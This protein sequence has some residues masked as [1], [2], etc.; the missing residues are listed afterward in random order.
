MS[1]RQYMDKREVSGV[2]RSPFWHLLLVTRLLSSCVVVMSAPEEDEEVAQ[3]AEEEEDMDQ[4]QEEAEQEEPEEEQDED[5][6]SGI[7][8]AA[9]KSSGRKGPG[10]PRGKSKPVAKKDPSKG[11]KA[12]VRTEYKAGLCFPV[13]K[14][15]NLLRE[16]GYGRVS[17]DASIYLTGVMEYVVAE[18]LELA[19][20]TV[21][22]QKKQRII[23]RNIQLAIRND[24]ELNKYM[25]N[26]TIKSGGVIPNIHT[27]LMPQKTSA[28]GVSAGSHSQVWDGVT[29]GCAVWGSYGRLQCTALPGKAIVQ[30]RS[31]SGGLAVRCF[32][33]EQLWRGVQSTSFSKNLDFKDG[34]ESTFPVYRVLDADGELEPGVEL[35]FSLEEGVDM[36]RV[37]LKS[38]VYDDVLMT[39]QRQGRISF[40][41]TNYGEEATSVGTAAAL[42]PQDMIW[43]QYRELGA[44]LWRGLTAQEIADQNIG[45]EGDRSK[46]RNLQVHYC[47]LEKNMQTVHAVLG[48]QIPQAPGAGYA[49]RLDKEDRVSVAYFGDGAASEGDAFTGLNFASVYGAQTLFI[50][51][52]NGYSISTGVEDQYKGDGIAA[53]GP[54]LAIPTV[55]VDGNDLVA[56]YIATEAARKKCV[57]EKTPILLELMTYRVGDHTTSDDSS[58]YRKEDKE[59]VKKLQG[60]GPLPR[61]KKFLES[62]GLW[63]D[64]KSK[65]VEAA[66]RDEMIQAMKAGETKK[67]PPLRELF[68]DVF[69]D[70]P[71]HLEEQAAYAEKHCREYSS[72]YNMKSVRGLDGPAPTVDPKR[73][74]SAPRV[75]PPA[76]RGEVKETTMVQ[77]INDA[78]S[79]ALSSD[80]RSVLFGEDVAFGGVFRASVGLRD[81][82][83][84]DRVL[85]APVAEQAI[86]AFAVGLSV[87]GYKAIAEIQFADYIFPAFDQIVNEIAKWGPKP[88]YRYRNAGG[89]VE[90]Y[91]AHCPGLKIVIPRGPKQAKG[92]L[93]AAIR[94]PDPVLFFEP[95]VLY[96]ARIQGPD[97]QV[98]VEDYELPI[99]QAAAAKAAEEGISC[100]VIDLQTIIPWDADTVQASVEKTGR[101]IIAHEAA[102]RRV[103]GGSNPA[104]GLL[105]G[106]AV[107]ERFDQACQQTSAAETGRLPWLEPTNCRN[108]TYLLLRGSWLPLRMLDNPATRA[109]MISLEPPKPDTF[110]R[111]CKIICT[112][113]PCCWD[114]DMLTKLIDAC[115]AFLGFDNL[116]DQGMNIARLNFSHGD[117]EAHGKTVGRVR[118]GPEIRTGFFK[119]ELAGGKINL[120]E[121]Q[122]LKLVTDYSFKGD[123]KTLAVSYAT[124]PTAVKPGQIILAAD[125]SLS[126]RVKSCGSDHV[127]TE[128]LN[129]IAI[130]EKKNMNLPGVKVELPVLQEKD[131]KDLLEFG[132]PQG[133]DFIA[134]SFVQD[135]ADVKLIRDTLGMRGRTIKII[136]KIE[137]QEGINNIDEIVKA[138]DGVMVA[139]HCGDMGMEIDIEK[140]G[141]VQKLCWHSAIQKMI[142]AKCNLMGS[143]ALMLCVFQ[144]LGSTRVALWSLPR[145]AVE[146]GTA[147]TRVARA[148]SAREGKFA[149]TA[150][151]MLDS[152]ERA[153]RPTRAEVLNAVLDGTDVVMLSGETANGK[154]PE[155]A[156]MTMRRI[157]E[158]AEAVI[159]YEVESVCSSAVKT[160]VDSGK[161]IISLTETGST[162]RVISKYRPSVPILAITASETTLRQL[163]AHRGVVPILTASFQ[164]T[165]SVINKALVRAK[166]L[167][168]VK[169]GDTVVAIHGQREECPGFDE[170]ARLVTAH[171]YRVMHL[172]APVAMVM[173]SHG[174]RHVWHDVSINGKCSFLSVGHAVKMLL[175]RKA[176]EGARRAQRKLEVQNFENLP[177]LSVRPDLSKR[178]FGLLP[179]MPPL[180]LRSEKISLVDCGSGSTRA[181]FFQDDGKS[182]VSWEKSSWRGHQCDQDT[183]AVTMVLLMKRMMMEMVIVIG[184]EALASA[185]QDEL[186]LENLL[187]LLEQVFVSLRSCQMVSFFLEQLQVCV[188]LREFRECNVSGLAADTVAPLEDGSLNNS[189][190]Q[191]FRDRVLHCLGPRA[192]FMVLSG[193]EEASF[194]KMVEVLGQ[195][196]AD[197]ALFSFRNGVLAPGGIAEAAGKDL[198]FA[199]E[200]PGKLEEVRALAKEQL[201]KLPRAL[202]GSFALV[203]WLGLYVAGESTE[204]D[205]LMGLGYNRWLAHQ[206]VLEAV[207]RHL[208]ELKRRFLHDD[209]PRSEPIPRRV[210]ISWTYGIILQEILKHCF[211][212]SASFYCLKGINWSTGHYL[213]HREGLRQDLLQ[214]S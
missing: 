32:S 118:E 80:N 38:K 39:M 146:I 164:G 178:D 49:Y 175:P 161:L 180:L 208:G 96:R 97:G 172:Q 191:H 155:A 198:L 115:S 89:G 174:E 10:R 35:P 65:E 203:E 99:G 163:V 128:V 140:V 62:K 149:V 197:V 156:V 36:M 45:N 184:C 48:T 81:K 139:R 182:H 181:L 105:A 27:V 13:A 47:M 170:E 31:P 194:L 113:G 187:R 165:D 171:F 43:P 183:H 137:N 77:A 124:L 93:L 40:Y 63:D 143:T 195:G 133:V 159:D 68:T 199:R 142:I 202:E 70:L 41:C 205:L 9:P 147:P 59:E 177:P 58:A 196:D 11:K 144:S 29:V 95:K 121:G 179:P 141:L 127:I 123:D 55:R 173:E 204:R 22:E 154:F 92:L 108:F 214:I 76:P 60:V 200:L 201:A 138:T 83:G 30:R 150:T 25:A 56:V 186:R 86:A 167:G 104:A 5:D 90:S 125:G 110:N 160:V 176:Q 169:P 210:A 209:H 102:W 1:R 112:M 148:A 44:F 211:E 158:Q 192:Q 109:A 53:R 100:E 69:S 6:P 19:G 61:W 51:R 12:P 91:F 213:Q 189:S 8:E 122:D 126:L 42:K 98:P 103:S 21:K 37:M 79:I 134:A 206:E 151:Q 57:E 114:V 152:M 72:E 84:E 7:A 190:L 153:P 85:N 136:S 131:K 26:V 71:W 166:E 67:K 129:D 2:T 88:R 119:E 15:R 64:E 14:V 82:F 54:A 107:S 185:L 130:G 18:I 16:S 74:A 162:A 157:C 101:L 117:H 23:P 28:K 135:A 75:L 188:R 3:D 46:G 73:I 111:K 78:L 33:T 193:Q 4:E 145:Q 87:A 116:S 132:I 20:N 17:Q 50:C 66:A 207:N 168:M 52:N 24:E 120:K 212:T 106:E 34:S 94:D